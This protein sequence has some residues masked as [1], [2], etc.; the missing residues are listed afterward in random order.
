MRSNLNETK[1]HLEKIS[2]I[3]K[4]TVVTQETAHD[5]VT[6]LGGLHVGKTIL[7]QHPNYLKDR[8]IQLMVDRCN[9]LIDNLTNKIID[10]GFTL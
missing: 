10:S 6:V 5:Y 7:I 3:L 2:N 4:H 9:I 1:G 8:E